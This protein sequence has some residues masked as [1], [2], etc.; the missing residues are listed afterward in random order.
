VNSGTPEPIK[1]E[2]RLPLTTEERQLIQDIGAWYTRCAVM[3]VGNDDATRE[4]D[5]REMRFHVH[6]LQ[7]M[8]MAQAA[9]RAYPR[10]MRP[11]GEVVRGEET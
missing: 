5:L 4:D 10:E 2:P 9:A 7:R 1:P 3:A 11:L 6:A 8:V